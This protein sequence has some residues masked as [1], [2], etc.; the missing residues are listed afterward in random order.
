MPDQ[1]VADIL[2]QAED[3]AQADGRAQAVLP[4]LRPA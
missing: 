4:V 3:I 1:N 2:Q